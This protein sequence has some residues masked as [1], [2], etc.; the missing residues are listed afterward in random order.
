[1]KLR[2]LMTAALTAGLVACGG[3]AKNVENDPH[4]HANPDTPG[5]VDDHG[6]AHHDPAPK[7]PAKAE[8]DPAFDDLWVYLQNEVYASCA[9]PNLDEPTF[10]YD[11]ARVKGADMPEL[12]HL[13]TCL[14]EGPLKDA[15]VQLLGRADPRGT[16][17]YNKDLGTDR[18]HAVKNFLVIQGVAPERIATASAGE[19]GAQ[20]LDPEYWDEA[21]RVDIVLY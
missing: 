6:H 2:T 21:R 8:D 3:S 14:T 16:V 5:N 13:A 19:R 4:V 18:A 1:M 17:P 20:Q 12:G 9:V 11:S 15:R 7:T 10:R